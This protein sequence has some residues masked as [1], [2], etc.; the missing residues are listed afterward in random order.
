MRLRDETANQKGMIPFAGRW[1]GRL[2]CKL[3]VERFTKLQTVLWNDG[4]TVGWWLVGVH[5][6]RGALRSDNKS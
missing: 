1:Q 5:K 6:L 3:P 4:T 2:F